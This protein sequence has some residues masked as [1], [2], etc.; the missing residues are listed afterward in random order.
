MIQKCR[1][2]VKVRDSVRVALVRLFAGRT[3]VCQHA[4]HAQP[5]Q[6]ELSSKKK[7]HRLPKAKK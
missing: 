6:P 3:T 1:T 2:Q 7:N 4:P 5:P